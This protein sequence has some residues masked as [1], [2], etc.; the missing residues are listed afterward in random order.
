LVPWLPVLNELE[1]AYHIYA[2]E[3]RGAGYT[4][5][6][7]RLLAGYLFDTRRRNRLRLIIHPDNQASRR[8]AEKCGF[9]LEGTARGAWFLRGRHHDVLVY[10]LLRDEW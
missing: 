7:L 9:T 8:V 10:A 1:L 3:H 4:T 6:G 2:G 5:E